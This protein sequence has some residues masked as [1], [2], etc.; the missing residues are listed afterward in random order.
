MIGPFV[1]G[2]GTHALEAVQPA[3]YVLCTR[4]FDDPSSVVAQDARQR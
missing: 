3:L 2:D 4:T 1:L